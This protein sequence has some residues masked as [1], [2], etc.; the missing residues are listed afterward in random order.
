MSP[1][2]HTKSGDQCIDHVHDGLGVGA[3]ALVMQ[4]AEVNEAIG[5]LAVGQAQPADFDPLR[6]DPSGIANNRTR[7]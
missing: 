3:I 6:L 7:R 2:K 5:R 4:I 1:V